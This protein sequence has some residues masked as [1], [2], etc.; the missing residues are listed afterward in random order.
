PDI[1]KIIAIRSLKGSTKKE[2]HFGEGTKRALEETLKLA[3]R[4][5]FQT[6]I[7]NDAVGY[8]QWRTGEEYLG[9]FGH[10]DVVPEG[11]GW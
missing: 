9:L 6:E 11:S 10:L 1:N 7:V 4:Y 5:G 8:A 3:D 2:A